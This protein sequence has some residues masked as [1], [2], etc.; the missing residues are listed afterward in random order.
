MFIRPDLA[1][2][3]IRQRLITGRRLHEVLRAHGDPARRSSCGRPGAAER[4]WASAVAAHPEA[5][6]GTLLYVL[7]KDD[8]RWRIAVAQNTTVIDHGA[9]AAC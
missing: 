3:K 6:P 1:V 8:G 9:L 2:I 4:R 5:A 7:A